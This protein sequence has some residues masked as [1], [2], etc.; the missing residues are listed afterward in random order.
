VGAADP[1]TFILVPVVL[2]AVALSA[3][4]IPAVRAVRIDPMVALKSE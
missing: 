3:T 2:T 4:I 1:I